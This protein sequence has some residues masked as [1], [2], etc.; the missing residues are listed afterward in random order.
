MAI[1]AVATVALTITDDVPTANSDLDSVTEDDFSG[2][3]ESVSANGNVLSAAAVLDP[4]ANSTDGVADVQGADGASVTAFSFGENAGTLGDPE[5]LPGEYGRLLLGS[6]GSYTYTLNNFDLRVQGLD[7]NDTLTETFT[8]RITDGDG[9]FRETT[10][11]ITI[12]GSNDPIRI[13]GLNVE[14]PELIVDEDDLGD[15]SSPALLRWSRT[16]P[17]R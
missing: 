16:A 2:Q 13:G 14:G 5:G 7:G 8:Y 15:G 12:N 10:L 9:D 17:S 6:D 11:E 3:D 1:A 4:D